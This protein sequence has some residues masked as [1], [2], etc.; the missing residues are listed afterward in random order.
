MTGAN[1]RLQAARRSAHAAILDSHVALLGAEFE[2]TLA[3]GRRVDD[4]W[5]LPSTLPQ[6]GGYR[7]ETTRASR[8][9]RYWGGAVRLAH[10][11]LEDGA[12]AVV[13]ADADRAVLINETRQGAQPEG[14][15]HEAAADEP[16][17]LDGAL[18]AIAHQN[19]Q[20][21]AML[22]GLTFY[23]MAIARYVIAALPSSISSDELVKRLVIERSSKNET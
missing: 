6:S 9:A 22:R 20:T 12:E 2:L 4:P 19:E 23:N 14:A 7:V 10:Q 21:L 11:T 17:R 5:L 15:S 13:Q 8:D 16:V 1:V 18:R 3:A